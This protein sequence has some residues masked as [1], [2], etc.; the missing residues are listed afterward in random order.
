METRAP[1]AM[2]E[3]MVGILKL[4]KEKMENQERTQQ[5]MKENQERTQQVQE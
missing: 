3:E 1:A 4:Q 2:M 5:E